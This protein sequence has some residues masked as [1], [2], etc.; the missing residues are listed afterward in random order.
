MHM[1]A[2]A[3]SKSLYEKEMHGAYT[4][5]LKWSIGMQATGTAELCV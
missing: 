3:S 5:Q 4:T 1:L 2:F